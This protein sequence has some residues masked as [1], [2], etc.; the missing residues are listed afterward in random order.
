VIFEAINYLDNPHHEGWVPEW[1]KVNDTLNNVMSILYS[2]PEAD[3][4]AV[5]DQGNEDLQKILD[6]YWANQ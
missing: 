3:V 1:G 6:E 5:M 4:Q 2:D